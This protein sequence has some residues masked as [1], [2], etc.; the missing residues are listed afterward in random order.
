MDHPAAFG[1]LGSGVHCR[2]ISNVQLVLVR[3]EVSRVVH[4]GELPR[5][6]PAQHASAAGDQVVHFP[7]FL[8]ELETTNLIAGTPTRGK[9][10]VAMRAKT[11]DS[12]V[13]SIDRRDTSWSEHTPVAA[14]ALQGLLVSTTI[15]SGRRRVGLHPA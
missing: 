8:L 12:L 7:Y 11:Q 9:P 2:F 5:E 15:D 4:T 1:V 10:L 13:G 6:F 3:S 14:I